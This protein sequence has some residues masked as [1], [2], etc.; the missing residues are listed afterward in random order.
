[1]GAQAV[2]NDIGKGKLC[3]ETELVMVIGQL[4]WFANVLEDRDD[5]LNEA[6]V[7]RGMIRQLEALVDPIA[8]MRL[9]VKS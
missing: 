8:Q 2:L 7:L 4:S 3:V 5:N 1:M 9:G 6:L